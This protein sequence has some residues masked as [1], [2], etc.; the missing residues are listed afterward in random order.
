MEKRPSFDEYFMKIAKLVSTRSTCTR[1]QVG[2]VLVR[3]KRIIATG[4]NGNPRGLPHC[5]EIGCLRD[6]LGVPSGTRSELC[7]GV[8]AEQNAIIQCALHGVSTEG[9]TIYV[10][11]SP[12]ILCG[13]MIINAGI[14]RVVYGGEYPDEESLKMMKQAGVKVEKYVDGKIIEYAGPAKSAWFEIKELKKVI[15]LT[16]FNGS[17][18]T[19]VAKIIQEKKKAKYFSLSDEIR[20]ECKKEGIEINREN[21]IRV[22]N[23]LRKEYGGGILAKRTVEKI[24]K[25]ATS[26]IVVDSIRTPIEVEI[27]KGELGEKFVL[28]AVEAEQKARYEREKKRGREGG[29]K[30]FEEFKKHE[31][32]ESKGGMGEKAQ[33]IPDTIE[34]AD[35]VI[36]NNGSLEELNKKI[37]KILEKF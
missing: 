4:Y 36:K 32:E 13:K 29:V 30:N 2:A 7:T 1:R 3:D 26:E 24:W 11:D 28:I 31:E 37:G 18:K 33:A 9:A 34:L 14:R 17:G 21:L 8:H 5:T 15:G 19:T 25:S 27:L 10:T 12:C 20:E 23:E 35:I 6:K 22:G 16:G